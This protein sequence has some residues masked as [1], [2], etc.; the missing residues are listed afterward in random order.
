MTT[1]CNNKNTPTPV[2]ITHIISP[3]D[4]CGILISNGITQVSPI[5]SDHIYSL[6]S[7][8][9]VQTT[10]VKD[11]HNL[12]VSMKSENYVA[13]ENDC[14]KFSTLAYAFAHILHHNTIDKIEKTGLAVGELWY[15]PDTGGGHAINIMIVYETNNY[16]VIFF[17]PQNQTIINL[18]TKEK[19]SCSF[20]LF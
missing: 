15:S 19:E 18:S 20:L 9:W 10:F 11:Y 7:K 4:V 6:P 5:L 16:N 14:D 3:L 8:E 17:E 13:E 2:P 1:G 12:L